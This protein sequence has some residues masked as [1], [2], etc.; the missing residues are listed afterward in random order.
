MKIIFATHNQ[1][2]VIEL[3]HLIPK[4]YNILSL[5]DIG[6]VKEIEETGSTLEENAKIKADYVRYKYGLDCF[7]DDSGL[8]VDALKGAPGVFSA[9]YAGNQKNNDAN[10]KKIWEKL[11]GQSSTKATFRSIFHIHFNNKTFSFQG[12]VDGNLIFEKRG[13][14]G[15][16]YD[17][18]FIPNGY[19]QTFAELGD[20]VKNKI[21][22]RALATV[23]FLKL[24]ERG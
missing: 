8:E 4:K 17:P 12:K 7:S 24:L 16:G 2:K 3:S 15:F 21:S 18:I 20:V 23:Q 10:I 11:R 13:L 14:N 1:N 5:N 6:C 19:N 9:R 22:H